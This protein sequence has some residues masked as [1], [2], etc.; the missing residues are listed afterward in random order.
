MKFEELRLDPLLLKQISRMG[1]TETTPIQSRS[2]PMIME[3][4]DL[5]GQAQTGTGKTAAFAVP[6]I[7]KLLGLPQGST[8]VLVVAPTREL[9]EQ[10]HTSFE[11]LGR[12]SGI[13]STT[14]YGGVGMGPQIRKLRSRPDVVVACPGRLLD[15]LRNGTIDLSEV[16][17]LVLDE[18]DRMLDMGFIHDIRRIMNALPEDRQ[19]LL[20]SATLTKEIRKLASE[21]MSE[22]QSVD[23]GHSAPVETVSH[24]IYPVS[25]HLKTGLLIELLRR[26]DA[27][28]VIV[29]T[30]TKHRANKVG[31]HLRKAGFRA[32]SLQGNLSQTRRQEALDGFR[33]GSYQVLVATDIAARGIDIST[34]SHVINY[35]MPDTADAYTHRIGRT[36]RVERSGEA[37][38]LVTR[39][40]KTMV[41][42]IE[43]MLGTGIERRTMDGF[44]YDAVQEKRDIR[45]GR[46]RNFP[47]RRRRRDDLPRPPSPD[48]NTGRIRPAYGGRSANRSRTRF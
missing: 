41:R 9:A 29:F 2:I 6:I 28:S 22:P 7:Q 25:H 15:H 36:G 1:Y 20:F 5:L 26:T 45:P 18:A 24:A 13:R 27:G 38:T 19:T 39:E 34:I 43:R 46:T 16:D 11:D 12:A 10:I 14:V 3:G 47:Y 48:G 8:R 23:I 40:D 44:D 17:T 30:R 4:K 32:A 37:F 42:T 31:G 35:D 21:F 33:K